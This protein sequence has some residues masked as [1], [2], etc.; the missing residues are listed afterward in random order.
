MQNSNVVWVPNLVDSVVA[1]MALNNRKPE[2]EQ[3]HDKPHHSFCFLSSNSIT[4]FVLRE[5]AFPNRSDFLS[6]KISRFFE[7]WLK[8]R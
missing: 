1:G 7:E 2:E 3:R 8:W 4:W 6:K 5:C